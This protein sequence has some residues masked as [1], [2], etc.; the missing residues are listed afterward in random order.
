MVGVDFSSQM[1]KIG[2]ERSNIER[3]DPVQFFWKLKHQ[4]S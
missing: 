1:L 4:V 3:F 2:I